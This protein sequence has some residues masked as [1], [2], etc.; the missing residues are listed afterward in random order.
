MANLQ[1]G[2]LVVDPNDK[3]LHL[4]Q[5][6]LNIFRLPG[7]PNHYIG[8]KI[9][10]ERQHISR[11]FADPEN[12]VST[13]LKRIADQ[14]VH[15]AETLELRDKRTLERDYIPVF[16][17][18]GEHVLEHRGNLWCYRDISDKKENERTLERARDAAEAAADAKA[19]FLATMSHEIRTPM[20]GVIGMTNL[21]LDTELA[22]EQR[23]Y[24]ETVR[25]CGETLLS[26]INDI[27]DFSKI[28]AGKLTLESVPITLSEMA[29]DLNAMF[30]ETAHQKGITFTALVPHLCP[31]WLL[32][33]HTDSPSPH[34]LHLQRY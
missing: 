6:F 8:R 18:N 34:K 16:V 4:N 27:L 3:I 21:L 15:T 13:V 32:G 9:D 2:L 17:P 29:S 7:L 22:E 25:N 10:E 26:L 1:E 20:N 11:H 14:Q 12:Y 33:I 19:D 30:S 5:R 31:L 24:A 23:E 28:E